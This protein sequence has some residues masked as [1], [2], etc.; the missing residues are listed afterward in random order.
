MLLLDE[1]EQV[2][3]ETDE[4]DIVVLFLEVV[5]GI[6][7]DEV[8][9]IITEVIIELDEQCDDELEV[10]LEIDEMLQLVEADEDD[11]DI[12]RDIDEIE[13]VEYLY[14]VILQLVDIM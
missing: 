11:D 1:F 14:F 13:H 7:L 5:N 4:L 6:E 8:D 12:V 2:I 10:S 9:D 3:D